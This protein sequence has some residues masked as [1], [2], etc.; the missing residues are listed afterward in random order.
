[1]DQFTNGQ[2]PNPLA[3]Y[4]RQ[5][6]IYIT[7]PS[8]GEFY[9]ADSLDLSTNGQ[10]AVY[11]MSAKDEL[12][13]KTPDAL[14][15]GQSYVEVIKSCIPAIRDPWKMPSI[16]MD[17]CLIA[18]RIATYGESMD[19]TSNCPS[20]QEQ[21]TY[22]LNLTNWLEKAQAFQYEATLHIDPLTIHLR[23]Y[24]YREVTNTSLKTFEQQR[25]F[26]VIN[27][28]NMSDADKIE[29]FN[30]SFLKI[31]EMT[32]DTIAG[33]IR[34]IETPEGTSQ[35]PVQIREFIN[36]APTDLF[37]KLNDHVQSMRNSN[38]QEPVQVKCTECE[39]PY[40]LPVTM[41]QSNFFA[42]GS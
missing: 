21:N 12:L 24:S 7:L 13:F 8:K 20:C 27:D 37:N 9:P 11:A 2:Q 29:K 31:T 41:D 19:V 30:E 28:E 3:S 35:D 32:V 33:C 6:K 40:E 1:M 15:S 18:I 17:A 39:H 38:E 26:A 5:P 14:L 34:A 16:D 25:I 36:N 23:P 10:Y 22:A 42:Q 4:Y